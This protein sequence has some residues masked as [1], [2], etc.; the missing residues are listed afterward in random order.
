MAAG[1]VI[2]QEMRR[3][4]SA[5]QTGNAV[6][7]L[8][9]LNKA[10]IEISLERSLSQVGLALPGPFPARFQDA[11][12]EQRRRSEALFCRTGCASGLRRFAA[13]RENSS[14]LWG[15]TGRLLRQSGARVDPTCGWPRMK[16]A[17]GGSDVIERMKATIAAINDLG[18]LVRPPT[19]ST[20]AAIAAND[21]LMQRAWIIREFGGR[22]RTYFAIATALQQPL[23]SADLPEM[24]ESHGRVLQAWG[25]SQSLATR[26]ELAPAVAEAFQRMRRLYFE[27]YETLRQDLYAA[28]EDRRLSGRFRNLFCPLYRGARFG[29]RSRRR[30]GCRQSRACRGFAQRGSRASSG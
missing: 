27:D 25:L 4:S 3:L 18:D 17:A 1:F 7:A 23:T 19:D 9:Y 15:S 22:E 12:A 2:G 14:K 28:A 24:H 11:L 8:S 20:P 26:A 10:T 21:L 29:G 13:V 5:T 16:R 30:G 6:T